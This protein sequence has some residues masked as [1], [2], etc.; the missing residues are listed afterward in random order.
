MLGLTSSMSRYF[1]SIEFDGASFS[2]WQIQP[3][4]STVEGTIE[5]ALEL[6]FQQPMDVIG[7]G[8]TDAGVHAKA[9]VAHI[10]I[11]PDDWYRFRKHRPIIRRKMN[12]CYFIG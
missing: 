9:Q 6:L 11:S 3:D 2:G 4:A 5:E 7:Q 8:R 10:D 1:L 12:P